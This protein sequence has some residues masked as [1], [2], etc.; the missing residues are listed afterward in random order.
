[1]TEQ[2]NLAALE[3]LYAPWE[4]PTNTAPA[5]NNP[6]DPALIRGRRPSSIAIANN[7]RHA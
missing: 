6:G 3:P 4:E 5:R 1:M 2:I 7:L